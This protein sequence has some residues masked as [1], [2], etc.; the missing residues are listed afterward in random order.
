MNEAV[1]PAAAAD[2]AVLAELELDARA[3]MAEQR[4]GVRRLAEV[5]PVGDWS[6]A[7]ALGDRVWVAT[8]VVVDY[9]ELQIDH[10]V[11]EVRQVWVHPGAREVG[12]GDGLLAEA[13][14]A[15]RRHG[16]TFLEGTALPGDRDTKNL[17]ER[18]GITARR[19]V[20]S[21]RL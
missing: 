16:C 4:G 2:L 12:L 9:L 18:A 15:A 7:V 11:A 5:P 19:I 3:A 6:D 13:I 8:I 14:A 20:V 17:Y 21:T 1:R 10:E